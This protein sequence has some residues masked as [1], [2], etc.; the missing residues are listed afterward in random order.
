MP[1]VFYLSY[2]ALWVLLLLQGV[3]LLLVYRHLGLMVMGTAEGVQRD[4]LRVGELAPAL[5]GV[6]SSGERVVW[7]P[8]AGGA[9]LVLF[10]SPDCRP[11]AQIFPYVSQLA[12]ARDGRALPVVAVTVGAQAAVA[13]LEDKFRPPFLC[14]ADEGSQGLSRYRVRV[15]PFGFVVSEDGRVLAK[16]LC[17]DVRRLRALLDAAGLDGPAALLEPGIELAQRA[18]A[19]QLGSERW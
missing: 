13:R 15:T 14:F 9:Q 5:T 18:P 8:K 16:G 11:C 6:T 2:A 19:T 7:D 3:L 12:T 10:A 1:T 4:G 17:S